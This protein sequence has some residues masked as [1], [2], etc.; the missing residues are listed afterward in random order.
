MTQGSPDIYN[1]LLGNYIGYDRL[2]TMSMHSLHADRKEDTEINLYIDLN[3]YLKRI[4]DT[5]PYSYKAENVLVAS[6]INACAHYRNYFWTRHM[7]KTN[8][9]LIWGYNTPDYQ[10]VE[11]NAH[12]R[13]RVATNQQAQELLDYTKKALAFLCPYLP[14]IYF[15]DCGKNEVSAMIYSL[16]NDRLGTSIVLTKDVYAY[17]LVAYCPDTFIYRPKKIHDPNAG[18]VDASWIVMK[19]N[20][21]RAMKHEMDYKAIADAPS[22]VRHLEYVLALSGMRKRHVKGIMTFN[23]ACTTVMTMEEDRPE[24]FDDI[25]SFENTLL[26]DCPTRCRGIGVKQPG[27]LVNRRNMLSVDSAASMLKRD[28]AFISMM[29]S[30]QDLYNP[31]AVM[32]INDKEFCEYPLELMEL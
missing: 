31:Q 12:F 11:Y 21:F 29:A 8:V 15:I 1:T 16:I 6:I 24:C 23:R 17:Q 26:F 19:R 32:E 3:S 4:W 28:P 5:R 20:L 14:Q 30:I 25:Y 18:I 22:N 9:F 7:I 10:P 27:D 2:Y 13:E